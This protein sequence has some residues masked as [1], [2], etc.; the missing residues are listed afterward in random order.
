[1]KTSAFTVPMVA[2]L[3]LT[4]TAAPARAQEASAEPAEASSNVAITPFVSI[5]S[6]ASTP[7]GVGISFPL[8]PRFSIETEFDYRRAEGDV[9]ALSSSA[10][11][12]YM[13][14]RIGRV[15][16]YLAAG[17]GLA[18]YGA[19]IIGPGSSLIGT[20]RRTAFEVNAGG[21]LK[22]P[23]KD[24]WGIRTDARW[25]KPFD[26]NASEHLRLSN[27]VSFDVKRR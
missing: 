6:R 10:N 5:D 8:N 1:M 18:Q 3:V 12:L 4:M 17:A 27:G 24:T 7:I 13:L 9:N 22:I 11:L 26:R 2:V 21:G 15:T 23:V 16:P 25:F 19:P 20:Q 14:P